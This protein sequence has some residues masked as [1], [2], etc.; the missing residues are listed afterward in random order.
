MA[1]HRLADVEGLGARAV[2]QRGVEDRRRVLSPARSPKR[3]AGLAL[4]ERAA[5]EAAEVPELLRAAPRRERLRPVI[6]PS[7]NEKLN[8]AAQRADARLRDDVD[9][10]AARAAPLRRRTD[11]ARRGST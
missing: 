10:R 5:E 1:G 3:E 6:D 11:R 7:R 2:G 4:D 8:D 9:E